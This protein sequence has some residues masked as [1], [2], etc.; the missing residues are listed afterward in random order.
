[1]RAAINNDKLKVQYGPVQI[2]AL[3]C[4]GKCDMIRVQRMRKKK[5]IE[6]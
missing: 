1:M 2:I 5:K 3:Y 6:R 4:K